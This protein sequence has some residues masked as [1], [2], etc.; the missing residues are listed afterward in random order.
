LIALQEAER[1]AGNQVL[2]GPYRLSH[3]L[4]QLCLHLLASQGQE[5]ALFGEVEEVAGL[6]SYSF[7]IQQF[8]QLILNFWIAVNM[9]EQ[10]AIECVLDLLV[11]EHMKDENRLDCGAV[12]SFER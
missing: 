5:E 1:R 2:I 12:V 11:L 3:A 8:M 10:V 9:F 4:P 7:P 6:R